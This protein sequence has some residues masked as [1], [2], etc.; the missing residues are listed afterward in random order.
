MPSKLDLDGESESS[1]N[2]AFQEP[3]GRP[4]L[5]VN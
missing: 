2:I 1:F 3:L 5:S 4:H